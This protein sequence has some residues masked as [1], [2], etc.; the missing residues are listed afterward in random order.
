ML[1]ITGEDIAALRDADLRSLIG[2]L[3]ES[4]LR[5]SNLP[6]SAVTWGGHQ[7]ASDGGIDVR[8]RL[9]ALAASGGFVPASNVAFQ[10]K[11]TD[12]T[13]SLITSEMRPNGQLRNSIAELV[14]GNGAYIIVSSA[15]N[16]SDTALTARINAMR[17]AV[18]DQAGHENLHLDFYDC[19][20]VATWTRSHQGLVIWV[21]EKIGRPIQGWRP[22]DAW[23]PSPS[24]L[25][26]Q[27]LLDDTARVYSGAN[28]SVGLNAVSGINQIRDVLRRPRGVVRL[29]GLSGV[30]KTRLAQSLF[31]IRVGVDCLDPA[32]VIYADLGEEPSPPPIAMVS[33]LIAS[34]D[35]AI[36]VIDNCGPELHRRITQVCQ[37]SDSRI[38][39]ITIEYDVQDDEP[40]GTDVFRLAPSSVELLHKLIA[41]HRPNTTA[42]D[43]ERIAEFSGGNARLA[44]SLAR[45]VDRN[46]SVAGLR[47]QEL[48]KRLFHQRQ[49]HDESLM[50]AAQA[51]SLLYSFQ[52]EASDG[53][54]AE[55]PKIAAL[56][57]MSVPQL[58]RMIAKLKE[59]DLVQRRSV[60][61]A[62]L[63]HAIANR[64]AAL[65]L[66]EI[67]HELIESKFDTPRLMKSFSRRL[68]FLHECNEARH[69]V[70][71]WLRSDDW[72]G[73]VTVL[74]DLG[75]TMLENIAPVSPEAVLRAVERGLSGPNV[76]GLTSERSRRRI[77]NV[78]YSVA[79]DANLFDRCVVAMIP[80]ELAEQ[81]GNTRATKSVME[82]LFYLHLSGTHATVEQRVKIVEGLLASDDL[83][84]Q[85]LGL[86]F[87]H[88]LLETHGYS[89]THSLEF[90]ARS[91]DYGFRPKNSDEEAHWFA[92][93]LELAKRFAL[94]RSDVARE[95]RRN[96][97]HSIWGLW[98]LGPKVQQQFEQIAD[99]IAAND[100]WQEGWIS[101][102][103]LLSRY[104][105]K[106]I[107]ETIER[108][109][110]FER[111]FRPKNIREKVKTIVLS[112]RW[113]PF[114][115]AVMDDDQNETA[116]E[117][118]LIAADKKAVDA[119][120][121]LGQHV[122]E[123]EE[124]FTELLP[125]LVRKGAGRSYS[126]GRGL[127]L[128]ACDC[129]QVWE[130]LANAVAETEAAQREVEVL[131]G[132]LNGLQLVDKD[133][134]EMLL[135]EAVEHKTLCE[136]FPLLQFAVTTSINGADRLVRCAKLGRAHPST[137]CSL[138][139][140][141]E[142]STRVQK[143]IILSLAKQHDGF[144][145]AIDVLSVHFHR[146]SNV[147]HEYDSEMVGA[148][149]ELLASLDVN[150][151][152]NMYDYHLGKISDVCLEGV[153]GTA[154][155]HS[156]CARLKQGF[157]D[158]SL[159]P[160]NHE[161]LLHNIFKHQ[162]RIALD[163]FY[164]NANEAD[165]AIDDFDSLSDYHKN[166]LGGLSPIEMTRWCDENPVARYTALSRAVPYCTIASDRP[167]EWTPVATE[168]LKK[169]PDPK[170]ALEAFVRRF[171]RP[172]SWSGSLA[173]IVESR[174]VLLDQLDAQTTVRLGGS[175]ETIRNRLNAQIAHLR[176]SE[177]AEDRRQDQRFE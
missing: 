162:P 47:D 59:R 168:L 83:N 7:D 28:D 75:L 144:R 101:A 61:R 31:D 34:H 16:T 153:E 81:I 118:D 74:N 72:L 67:P 58:H 55:L 70:D 149:R 86:Q 113:G 112:P 12:Y 97:A 133:L 127:A 157:E 150:I 13:P 166:P 82:G 172:I 89:A 90:G 24:G 85:S 147:G 104:R 177:E 1:E 120:V 164:G 4:E 93:A 165:F 123:D 155:A 95:V 30:G 15:A 100:Y 39:A 146:D 18:S 54:D 142:V 46:E 138:G 79:Y 152:D 73:D 169:C 163:T 105:G 148:G 167:A 137:F 134:C 49:Q 102:R 26:D 88:A 94:G 20:R 174:V 160:Y 17:A 19:N 22:Y 43:I 145:I 92:S 52:G 63:P 64:L 6:T 98:G 117:T 11:I 108:L 60:W 173:T 128:A 131:R 84:R 140:Q 96:I 115:Y 77:T 161:Q 38:S 51:C 53:A 130:K 76:I 40:E 129:R 136:W 29:V 69:I 143:E 114:E 159:R 2:K 135:E 109:R 56:T 175:I 116:E 44:L 91:R 14:S 125:E 37:S 107:D 48:F 25:D 71:K 66:S 35:R 23:A 65:A 50:K 171:S 57:E 80:L 27:Y 122:C 139:Y 132:F 170:A 87:L 119:A 151:R 33:N 121:E 141:S 42:P 68:G 154:V 78:L 8:V 21:R 99:A 111:R 5:R 124:L 3:C 176:Q 126:F 156:L 106:P 103:A 36:V 10:V 41:R 158:Y 32:S 110:A 45:A 9:D 62:V